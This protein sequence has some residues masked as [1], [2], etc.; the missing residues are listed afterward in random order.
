LHL[1]GQQPQDDPLWRGFQSPPDNAKP[2]V[3]W[4]W[5]NGNITEQGIDLDL[6]WMKRIG[7]GGFDT[8]DAAINTPQVVQTRLAYMTPEWKHAFLHATQL[9]AQLGLEES[10]NSSPG[11]S[12][13]GGPWVPPS[14]G[15][16]K[17]VWSETR[18]E[19]GHAFT[20]KLAPPP[21][22]TGSYQ[23]F[24]HNQADP[25][26]YADSV[27]IAYRVPRADLAALDDLHP[28]VTSS[29][30]SINA[31][32]LAGAD[33][34]KTAKVRVPPPGQ[35][36]WIQ[37]A[38][39]QPR[40]IQAITLAQV[41][42]RNTFVRVGGSGI[43][44]LRASD[45]GVTFRTVAELPNNK[46]GVST[47]AFP[48][49][50]ARFFRVTI[51]RPALPKVTP[52]EPKDYEISE[53]VLHPGARV[54]RV[55]EKAAF[56]VAPDLYSFATPA[57]SQDNVIA[58]DSVLDITTHM[59]PDGTLDWT[60]PPGQWSVLRFGYSLIGKTNHP[61]T[62]EATGLE[63]DKLNRADVQQYMDH[64]LDSYQSAIGKDL[65]GAHG[66]QYMVTDSWEAGPENWTEDM[67]AQFRRRRGYDPRLWMPVLTG[68]IVQSA[69][70]SDAFLWDFRETIADLV[71][72]EHYGQIEASLKQYGL[73]HYGESHEEGRAYVADGMQ[74]K[75]LDDIPMSAMWTQIPGVNKELYG[76][77]ADDRESAS[78]AHIYG[79]NLAAA[80]SM[81]ASK[82]PWG[83][84]P[85]TLKPTADKELA[86]GINR[87][88]IH[89]S[90][91]Q[92]LVNAAPGLTLG[93]YGQWFNRNET[94]A[95]EAGPWVTYLA[96]S[97]FLLQQGRFAA[98]ILYFYGEDSNLTAI[99]ADHSPAIPEGYA[100]DYVNADALIHE[101]SAGPG[102]LTTHSG[103]TYRVLALDPRSEHMSLPVL[104]AIAQ[105]VEN[106]AIVAG[107]KPVDDPSLADD[108]ARFHKLADKLFGDGSGTHRVGKG[109]VY[110][111][112]S[113]SQVLAALQLPPDFKYTHPLSDTDI[114]FVHR[115]LPDGDLYYIDNRNP[116]AE[117]VDATFR[118]QGKA[119][120]LWHPDT[121]ASEPAAYSTTSGLTTVPLSLEPYGTVFVVFRK[122][123]SVTTRSL[124]RETQRLLSGVEGPWIVSFPSGW[125]A[126]TEAK[127]DQL[128]SWSLSSDEG[129]RY[130]SG[131]ATYT[132]IIDAPQGWFQPGAHLWIDLGDVENLADITV[133]DKHIG[134]AWKPPFRAD[135]TAALHA[136]ANQLSIRVTDLWPNRIIGDQQPNAHQ[137][138]FSTF[139]PYNAQSHLLPSG[140]LGP[141][142]IWSTTTQ[143]GH[144]STSGMSLMPQTASMVPLD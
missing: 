104:E 80:E 22:E 116:R 91:H 46:L 96:R 110:A 107:A 62:A 124:P 21:S 94:W 144:A 1:S 20:G 67:I 109:T 31:A 71:A 141:V 89:S 59:H 132:K 51:E 95:E 52:D 28:E 119:P 134:I 97:S 15:M 63:V 25:R 69:Q 43:K 139:H 84:C 54:N 143:A 130:F 86:E 49:V 140:L 121:G 113:L 35:S 41:A 3:W 99:F 48:P 33:L 36:A 92:P 39:A 87:F 125:G 77:N 29:G 5:M 103:M 102:V 129:I 72:D 115:K 10:I 120:E 75:K 30:G 88:V 127:F 131:T 135:I 114:L 6:S 17:L 142:Q 19:G 101:I 122:S 23:S 70:A 66:L 73:K 74:V 78:V 82:A 57:V 118:I 8:I 133:N 47:V 11:W 32:I 26:F 13:T 38:F 108:A 98:D 60:P 105:L 42:N 106:G 4:H 50:T 126:P 137:Y 27:V 111:G 83:W 56:D 44:T 64:Y 53:L 112:Q 68:H 90:V 58:K 93:K 2:R 81:T 136:G 55:E 14:Q 24:G 100:F 128:S 18:V 40:N 45:D 138:T 65:M 12:E 85:A 117:S 7:I 16:K 79:Q 37:F 61:A 123:A 76:Y 34:N 9:G